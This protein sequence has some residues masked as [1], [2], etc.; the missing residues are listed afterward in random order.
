MPTDH[1]IKRSVNA[2]QRSQLRKYIT[3]NS[4]YY[5]QG[6]VCREVRER[7][8]RQLRAGH[9]AIEQRIVAC[10]RWKRNGDHDVLVGEFPCVGDS[11]LLGDSAENQVLT[12]AVSRIESASS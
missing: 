6:D 1:N 10:V 11:L 4:V 2:S 9:G 12:S 8:D 5:V 7:G 3:R